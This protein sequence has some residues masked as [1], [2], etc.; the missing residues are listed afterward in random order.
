MGIQPGATRLRQAMRI[1]E[2]HE[3]VNRVQ[4][5]VLAD[6]RTDIHHLQ[7]EWRTSPAALVDPMQRPSVLWIE[8]AP[9]G[10]VIQVN[11][12]VRAQVGDLWLAFGQPAVMRVW[13]AA[14]SQTTIALVWEGYAAFAPD[15]LRCPLAALWHEPVSMVFLPDFRPATKT[16]I[17]TTICSM[18]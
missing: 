7:W 13:N 11:V 5:S 15:V 3:Q 10:L 17:N 16:D 6:S 4:F 18:A 1:L 12:P 8:G 14:G 2:S 9:G